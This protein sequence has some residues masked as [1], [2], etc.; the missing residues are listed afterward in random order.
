MTDLLP[1]MRLLDA[2][3]DEELVLAP[4]AG[5]GG[6]VKLVDF[7]PGF[8]EVR[9]V[10][11][12]NPGWNG[13][14]D[15]TML[16]G[17]KAVAVTLR[18]DPSAGVPIMATLSTLRAWVAAGR[19]VLLYYTPYGMAE[20]VLYLRGEQLGADLPMAA[21]VSGVVDVQLQWSCPDG[22]EFAAVTTETTVMLQTPLTTG[23]RP[24]P[25]VY[26]RTYTAQV[27]TGV[28]VVT[29]IG[30]ASTA[31]VVRI[32][33]PVTGPVLTNETTGLVFAMAGYI[34][35]DTEY[36]E[37]DMSAKTV[38]LRG[39]PGADA[40]RRGRVTTKGWWTVVP[41]ANTIRFTS[42]TGASPAQALILSQDAWI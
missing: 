10:Q 24:Y 5:N 31:P 17:A 33:G 27:G 28:A 36:L 18:L 26:P 32:F 12:L 35:G 3:T 38:Q 25:L 39:V 2:A 29:N 22:V 4:A 34:I 21:I 30:T 19:D 42:E 8:P 7:S 6:V 13:A 15:Y 20:R 23:G 41:G 37:V 9:R 40:N 1:S 14:T 16:H 11:Y